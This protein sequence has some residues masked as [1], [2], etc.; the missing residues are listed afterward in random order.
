[1][2]IA[3]TIGQRIRNYRLQNKLSQ[4]E[5]AER[6]GCHHTY[7]GQIERGEKNASIESIDKI[8]SA[9]G[10]SLSKLFEFL[11]SETPKED[12]YAYQAYEL[13]TAQSPEE[14][15]KLLRFFI[16]SK[17]I[18]IFENI[19]RLYCLKYE[20]LFFWKNQFCYNIILMYKR[21]LPIS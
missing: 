8:A 13:I 15:K 7:I 10:I 14:Q 2:G 11:G 18:K 16:R 21:I 1:M 19:S 5:L 17:N 4:E 6:A 3:Q 20:R 9:L 12:D